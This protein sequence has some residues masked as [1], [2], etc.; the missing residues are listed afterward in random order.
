MTETV[1]NVINQVRVTKD[2]G[3]N[4]KALDETSRQGSCLC[5]RE[6]RAEQM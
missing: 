4:G 5:D 6:C 3:L 2:S 1:Q